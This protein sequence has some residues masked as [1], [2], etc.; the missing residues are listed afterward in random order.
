MVVALCANICCCR[1]GGSSVALGSAFVACTGLSGVAG[2]YGRC[3]LQF[4]MREN[5]GKCCPDCVGRGGV[6]C[7]E[8]GRGDDMGDDG[9]CV[10]TV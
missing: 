4:T 9:M 8:C 10:V 1:E 7:D 6:G 2:G 5:R 3:Y